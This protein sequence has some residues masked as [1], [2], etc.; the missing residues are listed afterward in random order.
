MTPHDIQPG[1]FHY[2][3]FKVV[4]S[5]PVPDDVFDVIAPELE[6]GEL[7]VLL[8]IIRRTFGFKK[9][10]DHISLNQLVEGIRKRDGEVLDRGAGVS[11]STAVRAVKGLIEKGIIVAARNSSPDRGYEATTYSLRFQDEAAPPLSHH[12]TRGLSHDDT[13]ASATIEHPLVSPR[14]IQHDSKQHD[15]KQQQPRNA[16]PRSRGTV[17]AS[18]AT[19]T[20]AL[21]G[22]QELVLADLLG[23]PMT[24]ETALGLL[25]TYPTEKITAWIEAVALRPTTKEPAAFVIKALQANWALPKQYHDKLDRQER[26]KKKKAEQDAVDR[27]RAAAEAAF[28]ERKLKVDAYLATLT[29]A[30]RREL[31]ATAE[32]R[33]RSYGPYWRE[34]ATIDGPILDSA[35]RDLAAQRLGLPPIEGDPTRRQPEAVAV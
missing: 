23:L 24:R 20:D 1:A 11:K 17:V 10:S 30:G 2:P 12:R 25:Q 15:S 16:R 5:T 22:A 27:A 9:Q 32:A 31:R 26:A 6:H 28:Q 14:N 34:R 8:Y 33:I 4:N 7:R 35:V 19:P 18:S 29:D 3:G 13:R 21:T